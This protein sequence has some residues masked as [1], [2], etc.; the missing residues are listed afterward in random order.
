MFT[1]KLLAEDTIDM[2]VLDV[3]NDKINDILFITGNGGKKIKGLTGRGK[4]TP[5]M[6]IIAKYILMEAV[7]EAPK[8]Q[9]SRAKKVT[10]KSKEKP[11]RTKKPKVKE[12]KIKEVKI[13]EEPISEDEEVIPGNEAD[14]AINVDEL[15]NPF[16]L[17][18]EPPELESEEEKN[19]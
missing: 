10:D 5:D 7:P 12:V 11:K 17:F 1:W 3:Q 8:K 2:G 13:K 9:R 6:S 15:R 19:L 18:D 14:T 4:G 16:S